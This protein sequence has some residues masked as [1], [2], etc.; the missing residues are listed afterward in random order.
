VEDPDLSHI[1]RIEAQHHVLPHVG[2]ERG[3]EIPQT[4]EVDAVRADLPHPRGA[5]QQQIQLLGRVRHAGQTSACLPSLDGRCFGPRTCIAV[6]DVQQKITELP[7]EPVERQRGLCAGT[8]NRG[9]Q[10]GKEH[11][12]DG[13]EEPFNASAAPAE[14]LISVFR[15]PDHVILQIEDRVRAMSVFGHAFP[16]SEGGKGRWKR[17]A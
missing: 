6:I 1:P 9:I 14:Y 17:T 12:T 8:S 4:L 16:L 5:D 2:G 7:V 10:I 15:A 3:R 13:P 11:L